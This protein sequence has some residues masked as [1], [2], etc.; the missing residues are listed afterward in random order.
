MF[1]ALWRLRALWQDDE[2]GMQIGVS[3]EP[4]EVCVVVGDEYELLADRQSE[5]L[6]VTHSEMPAVSRVGCV[7]S[8]GVRG[9][10]AP[11]LGTHRSR[12]SRAL[13][14]AMSGHETVPSG[15]PRA[16]DTPDLGGLAACQ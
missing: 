8:E 2:S 15:V 1:K 14:S 6:I 3:A 4:N 12:T 13:R 10:Q 9:R 7:I 5:Q 16:C 11:A